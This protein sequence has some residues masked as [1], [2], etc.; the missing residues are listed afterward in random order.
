MVIQ[1]YR[2]HQYRQPDSITWFA[3]LTAARAAKDR[4]LEAMARK[5]LEVAGYRVTVHRDADRQR[6]ADAR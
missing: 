3:V 5:E 2:P 4:N 6:E 1:K